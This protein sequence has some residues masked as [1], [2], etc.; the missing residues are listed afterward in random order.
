LKRAELSAFVAPEVPV[1]E[2]PVAEPVEEF[3][4]WLAWPPKVINSQ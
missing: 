2:P 4:D 3:L 1:V